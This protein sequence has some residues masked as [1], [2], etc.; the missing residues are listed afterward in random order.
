MEISGLIST[1]I[2]SA[3]PGGII[4]ILVM[5]MAATVYFW[6]TR[7]IVTDNKT[8]ESDYDRIR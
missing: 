6:L 5:G 7:W 3:G 1:I 2:S 4:V 8:E